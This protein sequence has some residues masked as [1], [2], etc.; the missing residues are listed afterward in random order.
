MSTAATPNDPPNDHQQ[1]EGR[2]PQPK[3]P[4]QSSRLRSY[5]RVF[6]SPIF[7]LISWGCVVAA[8]T[9]GIAWPVLDRSY[10]Q[11]ISK[12]EEDIQKLLENDEVRKDRAV[13]TFLDVKVSKAGPHLDNEFLDH[14]RGYLLDLS[15]GQKKKEIISGYV[16]FV[17]ETTLNQ[18]VKTFVWRILVPERY[19]V[20]GFAF[21]VSSRDDQ[22]TYEPLKQKLDKQSSSFTVGEGN[23]GNRL[24]AIMRVTS[25]YENDID[26]PESIVSWE[27]EDHSP[28]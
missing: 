20:S 12:L 2:I 22:T 28:P 24:V 10:Q 23:E 1:L 19:K 21:L 8:T 13:P 16:V 7:R 4:A 5:Q 27:T 26:D 6:S 3:D 25:T 9:F 18:P 11:T 17:A 15:Q 14:Y